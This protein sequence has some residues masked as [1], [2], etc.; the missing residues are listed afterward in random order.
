MSTNFYADGESIIPQARSTQTIEWAYANGASGTIPTG[1]AVF[2][3][4]GHPAAFNDGGHPI[5]MSPSDGRPML[6]SR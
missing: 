5:I 1:Q 6:L 2:P 4:F 3:P